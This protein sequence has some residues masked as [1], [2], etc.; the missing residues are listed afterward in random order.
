MTILRSAR[1]CVER[2]WRR[3]DRVVGHVVYLGQP[4][5]RATDRPP[6]TT[7]PCQHDQ[8]Q[9][10]DIYP[11][12]EGATLRAELDRDGV[13]VTIRGQSYDKARRFVVEAT[14]QRS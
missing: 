6:V 10:A 11:I 2:C 9:L 5:R 12:A 3:P 7:T 8:G 13:A 14:A 4:P 1:V